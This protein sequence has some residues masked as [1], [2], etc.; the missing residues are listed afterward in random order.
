MYE[1]PE[2][3]LAVFPPG[4]RVFA[5]A[6]A[7]CT[8]FALAD[9]GHDVTAVD[10]NPAQIDYARSRLAGGPF[11]P[12]SAERLLARLRR[13][14]TLIG[15]SRPLLETFCSLDD[16]AEQ[17]RMWSDRL[18]TRR[19]RFALAVGFRPPAVRSMYRSDFASVLPVGFDRILRL[20]LE[21]GFA[22][23][24][25]RSNPYA[26][27]LLLGDPPPQ[28]TAERPAVDLHCADAAEYLERVPPGSF[29]AFALSNILDGANVAY[30]DRLFAAV[31][32]ASTPG[33][34]LVLRSLG[35]PLSP[36]EREWVERDRALIW[37]SIRVEEPV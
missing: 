17:Q 25:N 7:G 31:R 24:A 5:V 27:R 10:V 8:A 26:R 13:L 36:A 6:S 18:D 19:F 20:R 14:A 16:V 11:V 28:R 4:A 2:V 1:D 30:A 34:K 3:E 33:A 29:D 35:E 23:H 21:R 37:G 32:G 15:W 22:T 12:G 9:S